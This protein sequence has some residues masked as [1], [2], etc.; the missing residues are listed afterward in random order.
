MVWYNF[1]TC[2][3]GQIGEDGCSGPAA[4][5]DQCHTG[6][7]CPYW[8]LWSDWSDCSVTCGRGTVSRSREC[9]NGNPGDHGCEGNDSEQKVCRSEKQFCP[10]W[11]A[12]GE[13]TQCSA[14]CGEGEQIRVRECHNGSPGD[15][16]CEGITEE[17]IPCTSHREQ[18]PEWDFWAR[19]STCSVTCGEGS[20]LRT[21]QCLDGVPGKIKLYLF[22]LLNI[23]LTFSV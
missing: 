1:R 17:V 16:G 15:A 2:K 10:T 7:A 3:N 4:K 18:C 22:K 11:S 21:R 5:H 13:F 14:T 9:V 20:Q 8:D 19:W 12:W 6:K 23:F